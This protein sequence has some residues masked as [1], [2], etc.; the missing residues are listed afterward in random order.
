MSHDQARRVVQ[1]SID[2]YNNHN[3]QAC[4]D[5]F[6]PDATWEIV[7]V[8][9]TFPLQDVTIVME[10]FFSRNTRATVRGMTASESLVG[11]EYLE[12]FDDEWTNQSTTRP[13]AIFYEVHDG[14]IRHVRQ[15]AHGDWV[16]P[17]VTADARA[18]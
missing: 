4:L 2:A 12:T 11:V 5:C 18:D 17:N 6:A 10:Q 16:V 9:R 15:Y 1:A 3:L 14:K 13:L 8:D 7:G